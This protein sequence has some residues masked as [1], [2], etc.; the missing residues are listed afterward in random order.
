MDLSAVKRWKITLEEQT[1]R[2]KGGLCKYCGN[3]RH[4]AASFPRKSKEAS[5]Q[6]E[7]TPFKDLGKGKKIEKP[8][9]KEAELGKFRPGQ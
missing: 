6:V 8:V 9:E 2:K 3:S 7:I 5:E 4:V 1:C